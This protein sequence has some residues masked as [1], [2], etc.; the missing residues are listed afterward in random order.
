MIDE[1][2]SRA[3][4]VFAP[5][6]ISSYPRSDRLAVRR[7]FG[8]RTENLLARMQRLTDEINGVNAG[9]QPSSQ[10]DAIA[11]VRETLLREHPELSQQALECL[12]WGYSFGIK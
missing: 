8:D 4:L 2:F 11:R 3:I 7:E 10:D 9:R 1:E 12:V 6:G 5:K